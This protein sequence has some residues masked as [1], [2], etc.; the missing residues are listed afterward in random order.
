MSGRKEQARRRR[1]I[2]EASAVARARGITDIASWLNRNG[3]REAAEA[4]WING[5]PMAQPP[6]GIVA[7]L[8]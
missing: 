3:F 2:A 7:T 4:I 6:A 5:D 8:R 1:A